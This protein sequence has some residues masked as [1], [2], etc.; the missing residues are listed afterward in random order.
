MIVISPGSERAVTR[1]FGGIAFKL[2]PMWTTVS[3]NVTSWREHGYDELWWSG[4]RV[5]K[6]GDMSMAVD[7][8]TAIETGERTIGIYGT[9]VQRMTFDPDK[10]RNFTSLRIP[11]LQ[12]IENS[13]NSWYIRRFLIRQILSISSRKIIE[14]LPLSSVVSLI[15][16]Y[17]RKWKSWQEKKT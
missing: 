12:T 9:D 3:L 7:D 15:N 16:I 14:L 17:I 6:R 8:E 11:T 2:W 4:N 10:S 13:L 5:N 1:H